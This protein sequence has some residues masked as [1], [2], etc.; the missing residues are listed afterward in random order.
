MYYP[1]VIFP[2]GHLRVM[3][4]ITTSEHF[5]ILYFD[6]VLSTQTFTTYNLKERWLIRS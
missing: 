1:N 3:I 2:R 4:I 6:L 5:E